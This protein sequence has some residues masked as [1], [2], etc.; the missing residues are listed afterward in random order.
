VGQGARRLGHPGAPF[1][2][3]RVR[4]THGRPQA[5]ASRTLEL[6]V[7][8]GVRRG[9]SGG[10]GVAAPLRTQAEVYY[11]LTDVEVEEQL[12]A[13]ASQAEA[14]LQ[15]RH[16]RLLARPKSGVRYGKVGLDWS[17]RGPSAVG[18]NAV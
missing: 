14:E 5:G 1:P 10:R 7:A 12:E 11:Q 3:S 17:K 9:V 4:A 8:E 6:L 16:A 13:I 18:G 15:A 2:P